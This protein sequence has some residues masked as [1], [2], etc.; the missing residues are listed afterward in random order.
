M[1]LSEV[2]YLSYTVVSRKY[3]PPFATLAL[4]QN[5]EGGG[6]IRGMQQLTRLP[7]CYGTN[8]TSVQ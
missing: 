3:T 2:A 7:M 4:V 1:A 5:A 8:D 6:L